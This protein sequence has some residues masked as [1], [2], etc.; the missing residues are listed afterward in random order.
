[1]GPAQDFG[2]YDPHFQTITYV[3][4]RIIELTPF[5]FASNLSAIEGCNYFVEDDRHEYDAV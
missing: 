1:M 5:Y 4:L 3:A 2:L